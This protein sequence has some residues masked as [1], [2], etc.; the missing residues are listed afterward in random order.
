[1]TTTRVIDADGHVTEPADLWAT[2]LEAAWR[3]R[4]IRIARNAANLETL[5]ID[6]KPHHVYAPGTLG[7]LGGIGMDPAK[8]LEPGGYTYREACPA[9]GWD[10]AARLKVLD[11]EGIDVSVL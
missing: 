6:G 7:V 2:S 8:R 1:M 11:E 5:L 9:G 10:P 4:A 3:P